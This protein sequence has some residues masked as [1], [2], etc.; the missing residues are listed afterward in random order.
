[1]TRPAI[2]VRLLS[3]EQRAAIAALVAPGETL[4]SACRRVLLAAAGRADLDRPIVPLPERGG[5]GG[6]ARRRC[7]TC[8]RRCASGVCV[9]CA[10]G[11]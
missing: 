1:M 7:P 5:L 4:S 6:A 11:L 2:L 8:G 3:P 9:A 10:S